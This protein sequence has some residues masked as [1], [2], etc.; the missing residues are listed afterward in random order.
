MASDATAPRRPRSLRER[1]GLGVGRSSGGLRAR[2]GAVPPQWRAYAALALGTVCIGWSGIF[3]KLAGVPGPASAFYRLFFSVVVL[4]PWW[5]RA[6]PGRLSR[7][8]FGLAAAGGVFFALDLA[9]W[10]AAVLLTSAGRA[11]LLANVAPLWVGLGSVMLLGERLRL[12]FWAGMAVAL[13]GVAVIVGAGGLGAAT[14]VGDGLALLASAFYAAYILTT[15][16]VRVQLDTLSFMTLATLASLPVLAGL[17][18][19]TGAP[20][21]GYDARAWLALLG[22]GLIS[23]LVGWLAINFALGHL[24]SAVVAVTLLGQPV[25][26]AIFAVPVLGERL[27]MTDLAGGA[28][29]LGGIYWVHRTQERA[30]AVFSPTASD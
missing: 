30:A 25:L 5:L 15:R 1:A 2:A 23:Q 18:V 13:A 14:G 6:R 16:Q 28:L 3:V 20:L 17:S 21:A 11:T 19:A 4:L 12:G 7:R 27:G 22:V 24:R 29:V 10:N 26:T 8:A 9:L